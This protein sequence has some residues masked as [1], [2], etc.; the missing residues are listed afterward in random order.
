MMEINVQSSKKS[1]KERFNYKYSAVILSVLSILY[2]YAII[3]SIPINMILMFIS[4]VILMV[5][6]TKFDKSSVLPIFLLFCGHFMLS[7]VSTFSWVFSMSLIY[8]LLNTTITVLTISLLWS[9]CKFDVFFR[10]ANLIGV[11]SCLILFLQAIML[12]FGMEPLSGK[13]PFLSILDY[14]SFVSTTWGFRL[15]SLFQEPSYFAIYCLPLLATNLKEKKLILAIMYMFALLLSSSSLGII[16]AIIIIL[17]HMILERRRVRD[18]IIL[19][20]VMLFS[21]YIAYSLSPYYISSFNRTIDKLSFLLEESTLRIAG[22]SYLFN[23][24]PITNQLIGVGLNQMSNFFVGYGN[25]YNY[26]NSFVVALITTGILGL[27][28][29]AVFLIY[30][31]FFSFKNKRIIYFIIFFMVA[32]IDYLIY[33]PLFFYLLTFIYLREESRC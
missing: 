22:Q 26:S 10:T 9:R 21:H 13:I 11:I 29:Y 17:Y 4:I 5:F 20:G 18:T 32:S 19:S 15:N 1:I 27:M 28:M 2:P 33:S 31:G 23:S 24:M 25:V 12:G 16:G 30:S 6:N 7:L 14:A 3:G 8:S